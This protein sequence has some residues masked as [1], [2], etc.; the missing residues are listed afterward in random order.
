MYGWLKDGRNFVG[1][2]KHKGNE[3]DEDGTWVDYLP[4]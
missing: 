2:I 3:I 4:F 1:I